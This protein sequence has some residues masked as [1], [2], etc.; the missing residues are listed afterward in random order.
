MTL[1]LYDQFPRPTCPART[2]A[3]SALAPATPDLRD[4]PVETVGV[5]PTKVASEIHVER[6]HD[7]MMP[8]RART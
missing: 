2:R 5:V 4:V 6:G 3:P 7:N 8:G 1:P